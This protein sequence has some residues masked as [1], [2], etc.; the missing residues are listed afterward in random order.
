M[1]EPELVVPDAADDVATWFDR[2]APAIAAYAIRRVGRTTARDVVADT[3]RVA[4]EQFDT[5]DSARGNERAWLFGIATNLIRRHWRTEERRLRAQVRS[6]QGDV[7]SVD[8][9][10]CIDDSVDAHRTYE[11]IVD[12][13][14]QLPADDRDLLVLVAWERMS[15]KEA[16]AVLGI[17]AGTVRSRLHRIRTQLAS[18][19]TPNGTT[20][21]GTN[22][23]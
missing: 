9:L 18:E 8:P 21:K 10:L 5:F 15:S 17:P 11:R 12:R 4:L 7:R 23:G 2:H 22:H 20:P 13:V 1:I 3:F 6:V 19:T 14:T 16:A